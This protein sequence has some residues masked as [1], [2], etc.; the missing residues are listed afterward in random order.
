MKIVWEP[1]GG[2]NVPQL[3]LPITEMIADC[4]LSMP[5]SPCMTEE[6][7]EWVVKCVNEFK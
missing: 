2:R 4:E 5:I 7:V 3:R 1:W 6:Q